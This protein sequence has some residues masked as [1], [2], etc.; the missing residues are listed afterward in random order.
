MHL[1]PRD[2]LSENIFFFREV[3]NKE[4]QYD[5]IITSAMAQTRAHKKMHCREVIR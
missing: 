4:L 3:E 1:Q 2:V 5:F